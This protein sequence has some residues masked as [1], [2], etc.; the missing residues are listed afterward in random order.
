MNKV[1]QGAKSGQKKQRQPYIQPDTARS[2]DVVRL[3]YAFAEG[4]IVGPVDGERSVLLEGT[5]LLGEN[6]LNFSNVIWDFR[7]GTVDQTYIAGFP[8]VNNEVTIGVE[9]TSSSPWTRYFN[10]IQL[11]A[12]RVRLSWNALQ[13]QTMNGDVTGYKINYAIDLSTNNGPFITVLETRVNDKTT[14]KYSR[15]HRID[16]PEAKTGWTI[17]V[18]RLTPNVYSSLIADT[19]NI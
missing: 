15:S 10:N 9:L 17:R 2:M 16:L 8:E 7:S 11:S 19:M 3:L 12:L 4:E 5:Q 1:I 14:T 13:K 6:S 18:R